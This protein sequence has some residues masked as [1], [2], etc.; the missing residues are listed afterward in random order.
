MCVHIM[1]MRSYSNAYI[2]NS[3]LVVLFVF[4]KHIPAVF[5]SSPEPPLPNVV[6]EAV[7]TYVIAV[8]ILELARIWARVLCVSMSNPSLTIDS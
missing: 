5:P 7:C 3:G 6:W 1:I 8:A 4:A 2:S